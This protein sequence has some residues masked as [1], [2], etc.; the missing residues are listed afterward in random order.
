MTTAEQ[1]LEEKGAQIYSVS[2]DT[3]IK[4]ALKMMLEKRIGAILVKEGTKFIGIWTER[5]LMRNT[6]DEGFSCQTARIGDH[7]T[8]KLIS[9]KHDATNLELKDMF[10]GR[11]LRHL[12]I[13]RDGKF[14]GLLSIG[15]VTRAS[16]QEQAE[17][18]NEL[19]NLVHLNYYDEWRWKKKNNRR[20][21]MTEVS[22]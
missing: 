16:L 19:N 3:T 22:S 8:K 2:P 13:E 5:D 18:L 14:I 1:I 7:M 17:M 9:A 21:K 15:D 20:V 4:E 12:M 10:L 6:V 11:R